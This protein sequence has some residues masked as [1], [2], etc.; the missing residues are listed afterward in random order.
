MEIVLAGNCVF[1][2]EISHRCFVLVLHYSIYNPNL[3]KLGMAII[4]KVKFFVFVSI[5]KLVNKT[6]C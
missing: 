6:L 2:A 1:L 3:L 5:Y 4:L